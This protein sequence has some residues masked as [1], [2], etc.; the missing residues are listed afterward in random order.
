IYKHQYMQSIVNIYNYC[1][2]SSKI[3]H[4]TG[5]AADTAFTMIFFNTTTLAPTIVFLYSATLFILYLL[6]LGINR[7]NSTFLSTYRFTHQV[8]PHQYKSEIQNPN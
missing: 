1:L 4:M 6:D 8:Q 7:A 2:S 5:E 3:N